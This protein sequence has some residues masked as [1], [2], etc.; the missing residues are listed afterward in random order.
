MSL[1][2]AAPLSARRPLPAALGAA[3]V[4]V[5]LLYSLN[6]LYFFVDDEGIPF[7]FAQNLLAGRGFVYNS[8]EGR[9][10]GYSDFLHVLLSAASLAMLKAAGLPKISAFLAGKAF[11]LLAGSATVAL[12]FIAMRRLPAVRPVG[13]VAGLTFLAAAGPL[14]MWSCS[15]LE[16]APVALLSTCLA[17]ALLTGTPRAD[18][19]ALI[20]AVLLVLLRIDGFVLAGAVLGSFWLFSDSSRRR[21]LERTVLLPLAAAFVMYHTW[22]VWYFGEWLSAPLYSKILHRFNSRPGYVLYEPEL[23]YGRRFLDT[24]GLT[25]AIPGLVLLGIASWRTRV[26]RPLCLAAIAIGLYAARVSDWMAGFRFFVPALPLLSL[27]IAVAV[28]SMKRALLARTTTAVLCVWFGW[29]AYG[30]AIGHHRSAYGGSWWVNPSFAV[31]RYFGPDYDLLRQTRGLIAPHTRTAFNQAGFLPFMLD[32][33]NMDDVGLGS[34]FVAKMPTTDVIFTETGRYS[35]LTNLP[36]LRAANA[37][38]LYREPTYVIARVVNL[39]SANGGRVPDQIL[40][41]RYQLKLVD[42]PAENAVYTRTHASVE[43]FQRNPNTFLENLAHTSR[44]RRAVWAG[45]VVAP[46]RYNID[47]GFL[48]GTRTNLTVG[49]REQAL[50]QFADEDLPVHELH[51]NGVVASHAA[52]V[53]VSLEGL[54]GGRRHRSELQIERQTS[55]DLHVYL[56]GPVLASRLTV[57]LVNLAPEP[58]NFRLFDLRVQGQTPALA[59][60]VRTLPFLPR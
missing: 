46:E 19:T 9:V 50:V 31:D 1:L 39:K 23:S 48:A 42:G 15:S 27:A 44:L 16:M 12:V 8:F 36:A 22:R 10:E 17:T 60:H 3:F 40:D 54:E 59:A 5:F 55:R 49:R 7:V 14:A 58:A 24:Y 47:L 2:S 37:Y 4:L 34:M 57:D 32:L 35:P 6:F 11:S 29:T 53:V 18:R 20:A 43:P 41:G 30:Y 45:K 25:A 26:G 33:D 51:L 13:A 21:R 28:S 52:V 38:L 56:P